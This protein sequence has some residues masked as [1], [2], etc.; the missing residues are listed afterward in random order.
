MC[1]SSTRQYLTL[2][3]SC[4]FQ[5]PDL[6]DLFTCMFQDLA[7]H[8]QKVEGV[9]Q[10]LFQMCKGVRNMFHFCAH[11]VIII[12]IIIIFFYNDWRGVFPQL[13]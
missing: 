5:V 1:V 3:L 8:S 7:H 11:K 10:L 6:D 4:V 9:G 13:L 2:F 12:I